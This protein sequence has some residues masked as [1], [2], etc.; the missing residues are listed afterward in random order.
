MQGGVFWPNG[1]YVTDPALSAQNLAAAAQMKG[2]KFQLGAEVAGH[3][4]I[5][6]QSGWRAADIR[7]E[8]LCPDSH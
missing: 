2:A 3:I 1:G 7:R 4:D 6:G 5:R 8:A